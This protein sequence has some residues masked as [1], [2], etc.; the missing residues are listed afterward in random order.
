M[1]DGFFYVYG[2]GMMERTCQQQAKSLELHATVS[3]ARLWQQHGKQHE[4]PN[5]LSEISN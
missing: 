5:T 2:R 4:A 1:P 3:L